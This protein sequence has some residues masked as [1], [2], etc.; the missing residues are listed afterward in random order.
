MVPIGSPATLEHNHTFFND[1]A[2][3]HQRATWIK[4]YSL[5]HCS[6]VS[7]HVGDL[8]VNF[9]MTWA[10]FMI[11]YTRYYLETHHYVSLPWP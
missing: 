9:L 8:Q 10:V 7:L 11:I 1:M 6:T 3:T 5:M 2:T 4:V